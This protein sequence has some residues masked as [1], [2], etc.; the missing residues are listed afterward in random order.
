V[1]SKKRNGGGAEQKMKTFT[2][3][4]PEN[5]GLGA[6]VIKATQENGVKNRGALFR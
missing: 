5:W 2:A 3:G 6:S 4:G 1:L